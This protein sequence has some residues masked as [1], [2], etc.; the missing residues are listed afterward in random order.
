MEI[1]ENRK[2][3]VTVQRPDGKIET[4]IHPHINY[5]TDGIKDQMN[6]AMKAANRGQVVSYRNIEAVIEM[7]ESDYQSKCTRCGKAIDTRNTYS[8]I[9][10]WQGKKVISHYC[11]GCKTLL[12]TIGQ[13]EYTAMQDRAQVNPGYEQGNKED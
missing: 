3:E 1:I 12:T 5:M 9:E 11:D 2:V 7:E 13:G 4:L 10:N 6:Q 8:Q